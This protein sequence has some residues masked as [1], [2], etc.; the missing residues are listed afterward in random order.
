[1]VMLPESS[2]TSPDKIFIKVLL[3]APLGPAIPRISPDLAVR[4]S[5]LKAIVFPYLLL[6]LLT[7]NTCF[8]PG[9]VFVLGP[10]Q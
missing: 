1:M 2:S 10:H 3:P 4:L 7:S 9:L 8:M 5:W 6:T